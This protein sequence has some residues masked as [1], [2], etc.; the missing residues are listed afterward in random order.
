MSV[1]SWPGGNRHAMDQDEH[2]KW[3]TE[4]YPGTLQIC[5]KCA[6]PTTYCEEEGYYDDE[7]EAYCFD[8]ATKFGLCTDDV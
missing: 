7:G 2:E 4:N 6:E 3:N 8:C 1:N 5:C